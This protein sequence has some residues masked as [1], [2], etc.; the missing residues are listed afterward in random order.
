MKKDALSCANHLLTVHSQ[1]PVPWKI[2][3][4][5]MTFLSTPL[6]TSLVS[7]LSLGVV[8]QGL[9]TM[10]HDACSISKHKFENGKKEEGRGRPSNRL[11]F[12]PC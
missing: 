6:L 12:G 8:T 1:N 4:I 3:Y 11:A 10:H 9:H 5:F 7:I 2:C